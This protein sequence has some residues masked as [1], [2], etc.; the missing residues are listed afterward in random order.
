[1]QWNS[2]HCGVVSRFNRFQVKSSVGKMD[3]WIDHRSLFAAKWNKFL[4]LM[5][6]IRR[7]GNLIYTRH[8]FK[9][10][11]M[12]KY[13]AIQSKFHQQHIVHWIRQNIWAPVVLESVE[14]NPFWRNPIRSRTTYVLIIKKFRF[15]ADN[16]I[17]MS[18]SHSEIKINGHVDLVTFRA[19]ETEP[20]THFV[21]RSNEHALEGTTASALI[22]YSHVA[23]R[24]KKKNVHFLSE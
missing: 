12:R 7:N 13:F 16:L 15:F 4:R 11:I 24:S 14:R 8:N 20:I 18:S 21:D 17:R 10:K 22:L 3:E 9:A 19:L 2:R 6:P 1:M 23:R 5:F